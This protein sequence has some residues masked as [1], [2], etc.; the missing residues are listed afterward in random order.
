[1]KNL[2]CSI[3]LFLSASDFVTAQADCNNPAEIHLCPDTTLLNQSNVGMG[4][5]APA[6]YNQIGED[7]VYK[8]TVPITTILIHVTVAHPTQFLK[9]TLVPD[10]CTNNTGYTQ[11]YGST[12]SFSYSV[13]GRTTYYLWM[14]C[15][16]AVTYDISFGADTSSSYIN[17]P[18]TQGNLQFDTNSCA[19]PFF[20]PAKP[21]YTVQ[22]NNIFQT[23][24]MTL[25]PL[26]TP[27]DLCI[28]TYF[29]NTTGDEGIRS[30]SFLFGSDLTN[31]VVPESIPGNYN[32]GF[33]V[34]LN[35][36]N[37]VIYSFY[38]AGST[39]R[40]D[41]DGSPNSCLE[42]KFCFNITPISNNPTGTNIHIIF[43]TDGFGAP[44]NG[45]V[46][47]G[48][49]PGLAPGCHYGR[50]GANSAANAFG[51][52]MND[53][54]GLPIELVSFNAVPENRQVKLN[55]QTASETNNDYFTV[56]RSP[57]GISWSGI[58]MVQ[59]SGNS[60]SNLFYENTD[61][62][63]FNGISYYRLKQTDYDGKTSI[64]DPVS[65][66]M[67]PG[68]DYTIYPNPA[69]EKLIVQN[70]SENKYEVNV[71]SAIGQR[72]SVPA[73]HSN[74]NTELNLADLT[75]G[76]YFLC[77]EE[78]HQMIRTVPITIRH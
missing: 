31:I 26:N 57:D 65:V 18:N 54:G 77:I 71:F 66:K 49:C 37:P 7:V 15:P 29:A 55:W 47:S 63:P 60:S 16:Q 2:F 40:G 23:N 46:N 78:E 69:N 5:D 42:Y 48:C 30:V 9:S 35:F 53:P 45:Y 51:F 70:E 22:Y 1:M 20:T 24:P 28:S 76:I 41:F 59:G 33:W 68:K 52:G 73:I 13:G 11:Y 25:S 43:V 32:S 61:P 39:G 50:A 27:G 12:S 4:D 62:H 19:S 17:H 34:K 8:I 64:S 67:N 10:S 6:G 75:N 21:F 72:I 44:F 38:D 14:D 36:T 56:E 74:Q 3:L 58:L